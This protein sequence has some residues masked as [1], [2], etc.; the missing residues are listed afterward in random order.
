MRVLFNQCR[1]YFDQSVERFDRFI[2]LLRLLCF[3]D[4][5]LDV[6]ITIVFD[7]VTSVQTEWFTALANLH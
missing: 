4:P 6:T 3:L 5:S 7:R 2:Q 1:C